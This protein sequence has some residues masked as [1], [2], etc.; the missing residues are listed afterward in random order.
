MTN[1]TALAAEGGTN[2]LTMLWP[3]L[4]MFAVFYFL[5]IR[6]QQKK[7]KARNQMLS[8]V[9]NGDKVV[10]IGGVHGTIMEITDDIVVL[11][12]NDTAKMTFDRS[13]INSIRSSTDEISS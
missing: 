12:V 13:A 10:T 5:L 2:L 7:S 8:A 6:P 1:F 11:R 3:F 9:K 4:L